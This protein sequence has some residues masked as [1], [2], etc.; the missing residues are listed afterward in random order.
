[1]DIACIAWG[2][3]VWDP[4]NL[5]VQN[6]WFKDG[7]LLPVEFAR[8]SCDGRITLVITPEARRVGTLW[9]LLSVGT[10]EEAEEALRVR[11]KTIARHI[12]SW[13]LS[14]SS[15]GTDES[16][17]EWAERVEVDAAVWTALPPKFDGEERTPSEEEVVRYLS[18][19]EG[20]HKDDAEKYV[21]R[22]P[23]QIDTDY[24]RAIETT[25]G[26]TPVAGEQ[27]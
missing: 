16:I 2:S 12:G 7:P 18:R 10:P 24:R 19:L 26:W 27:G 11:E 23:P 20:E 25:L 13:C 1:M 5:P 4:D 9:A 21:R 22:A 6:G 15:A 14:D 8:Q 3:L 17:V